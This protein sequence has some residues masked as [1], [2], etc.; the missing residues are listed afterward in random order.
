M[1][2][3][4]INGINLYGWESYGVIAANIGVD[5][6]IPPIKRDIELASVIPFLEIIHNP[7]IKG[8]I[9]NKTKLSN[10]KA[11]AKRVNPIQ[12]SNSLNFSIRSCGYWFRTNNNKKIITP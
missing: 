5:N 6:K 12:K 3:K 11:K 9:N 1:A 10:L 7:T 4:T 8:R 2:K